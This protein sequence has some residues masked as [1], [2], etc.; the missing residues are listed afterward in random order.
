MYQ[1]LRGEPTSD[2]LSKV[3][4]ALIYDGSVMFEIKNFP[5]IKIKMSHLR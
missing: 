4:K 5:G 3:M 1:F 2:Q